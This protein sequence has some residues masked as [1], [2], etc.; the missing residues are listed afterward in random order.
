MQDVVNELKA[1]VR[2][3]GF[4]L[5][6]CF[7]DRVIFI[8]VFFDK[9]GG[10]SS[11]EIFRMFYHGLSLDLSTVAY[12]SALPF[13][14]YCLISFVTK[15]K[16]SRKALDI[17][18]LVV[19]ILF[20]V[21][22]FIN[23]NVY[24]E[25][26][27]KI[28][29]R[30]IDAF[31]ASPS[32][33]IASAESTP[34]FLPI[35]GIFLGI[36]GSYYLY[37]RLFKNVAFGN[38]RT[39]WGMGFRLLIGAF[40]IFTFIR[41]GYGRATLNPSKAYYSEEAFNNHAAVSTQWESEDLSKYLQ[42]VFASNPD[43]TVNIL[44]THRPNIVFVLLEGFVGDLVE[45][46]GGEKGI[47]PHMETFIKEGVFF[48]RIYSASDRSDKG[49]IGTFSAFPAQGPESVIKYISKH[50]N[51][52]AF[53]QEL[54]SAGYH[55]SFYHGGQSEFY[56][57]KSY[58]LTHGVERVVDN[59]NFSPTEER[60]SWGVTDAVV[61]NRMIKDL[62]KEQTPFYSSIFTLVNHEPFQLKGAYK[63]GSDNNANKFRSTAYYTDSVL[64]DF[65]QQA[66][67]EAWY[68]NTLFVMIA[69]HG[70]RLPA[71]KYEI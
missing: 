23:V 3:F 52:H 6:I 25:W 60:V 44:T 1:F 67:K 64:N 45:S 30:A 29:K 56:N 15:W 47:T 61:L 12:I 66:K 50:E 46:M 24:R 2:F 11:K 71:E 65:V 37:L 38:I 48:D 19:L 16:F 34:V 31:F 51:M 14:V 69:D 43:S 18:T 26:G 9:I 35:L 39:Y 32:G 59:A 49:V 13:L 27:D 63:F 28:S 70:H 36:F 5:L 57:V 53:M 40:I 4:W 22:S 62:Q 21:V 58:M 20:F 42:P 17:Y 10:A 55:N 54:D 8:T 33:A 41:G 68:K 7:I